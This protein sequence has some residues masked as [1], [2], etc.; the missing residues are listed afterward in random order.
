MKKCGL[1]LT[2]LLVVLFLSS[3][4]A[5]ATAGG[6]GGGHVGGGHSS[7]GHISGSTGSFGRSHFFYGGNRYGDTSPLS[8]AV[9]VLVLGGFAFFV[10]RSRKKKSGHAAAKKELFE[11]IPGADRREKA[12]LLEQL[13]TAF[14][15]IQAAW[16]AENPAAAKAYCTDRLLVENQ[17]VLADFQAKRLRNHTL[18]VKVKGFDHFQQLSADS[19]R[20]QI[21][22]T[23]VDY[24]EDL[25]SGLVI[26][27]EK[28][29]RLEFWQTW[30]FNREN[31]TWKADFIQV[32]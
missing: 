4:T 9:D 28:Q 1:L 24:L 10:Y 25:N 32:S 2:S 12:Q 31:D 8:A 15:Q 13:Q 14:L 30:Y 26:D 23:A 18:S 19:V 29:Q 5:F 21:I 11:R 3:Q 22:F 27:G 7:G 17:R 6:H 20:V 16:E